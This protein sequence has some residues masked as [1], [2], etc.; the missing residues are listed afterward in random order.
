MPKRLDDVLADL[1]EHRRRKISTRAAELIAEETARAIPLDPPS[2]H[3]IQKDG[4][5][6][7]QCCAVAVPFDHICEC[8]TGIDW[9]E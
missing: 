9:D 2:V 6:F 8:E 7:C 1:P 4:Q 5:W 3:V